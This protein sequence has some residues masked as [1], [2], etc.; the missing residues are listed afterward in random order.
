MKYKT[1]DLSK[2]LNVSANTIRRFAE[3]GYLS[4]ARDDDNQYRYFGD[5]DVEKITYISKYRKIGLGHDEIA[6]MFQ[7]HIMENQKIYQTKM[8][9]ID[10]EIARLTSL[11]HML[12]DD[13]KM[14]KGVSDYGD[15]FIEMDSI[16]VHYVS[17]KT[18]R[19]IRSEGN[20]RKEAQRFLYDFPEI[21]YA[22]IIRKDDILNRRI[23]YEEA[24]AIRSKLA[25][26]LKLDMDR[27]VIEQYPKYPSVLRIVKLPI[28]FA[29][30]NFI[31]PQE[32]KRIL[33]DDFF[34]YMEEKG[35]TLAG[36]AIGVK[37]GFS[38]EDGKE[39][40]YIVLGMPVDKK[41]N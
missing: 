5:G 11:R 23:R 9:E 26:Q 35:Y 38:K 30:E 18:N 4:P 41:M 25:G 39:M 24:I 1:S 7:S 16:P 13:I 36:D 2:L 28:D 29:D 14:M 8:D 10:R 27:E 17:Y 37:I 20:Y 21:E 6:A 40:Q 12:K 19:T 31:S 22:Y 34:A 33:Y 15:N 32:V 3:K